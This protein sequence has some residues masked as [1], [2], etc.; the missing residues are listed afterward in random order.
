MSNNAKTFERFQMEHA[1]LHDPGL[2]RGAVELRSVDLRKFAPA[3]GQKVKRKKKKRHGAAAAWSVPKVTARRVAEPPTGEELLPIEFVWKLVG[4]D[5]AGRDDG[6][7]VPARAETL[8]EHPRG[9]PEIEIEP[10][11]VARS[12]KLFQELM[13]TLDAPAARQVDLVW[14]ERP[15]NAAP[16]L[17]IPSEPKTAWGGNGAAAG[18][19]QL[20]VM[21]H[22]HGDHFETQIGIGDGVYLFGYLVDGYMQ[23]DVRFSQRLFVNG[24]GIFTALVLA[25]HTQILRVTNKSKFPER[26]WLAANVSWLL[27]DRRNVDIPPLTSVETVVAFHPPSMQPGLNEGLVHVSVEREGH[28]TGASFV[29]FSAQTEVGG[30]VPVISFEPVELGVIRQGL[31]ESSLLVRVTARGRGPLT[32]MISLPHSDELADFRLNADHSQTASFAHSFRIDSANLSYPRQDRIEAALKVRILTDSFLANYRLYAADIPYRLVHLKK[33]LPALSFGTLR[34]G[35]SK[36][37]RLEVSRSDKQAVELA[38]AL[39]AGAESYLE[40]YPA[41]NDAYVFRF[42]AR[43]LPEGTSI[44]ETVELI[45]RKSGLRDHVKVLGTVSRPARQRASGSARS[46]RK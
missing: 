7:N 14:S 15:D 36:V 16:N 5:G 30:A 32:G 24:Q 3:A 35:S 29:N 42:D 41:R 4:S 21:D 38:V 37:M 11:N 10:P 23:P 44:S 40:A 6:P 46:P 2:L 27:P 20:A 8:D 13:F 31:D 9:Q 34:P 18:V 33:S 45:D 28:L 1:R 22:I 26:A 39:P 12:L 25:R 43:A 19:L 17:A